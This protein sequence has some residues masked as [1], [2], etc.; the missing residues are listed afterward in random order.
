MRPNLFANTPD[1][2]H[3][4]LQHGGRPAFQ[5]RL[6]P[7]RDARRHLRDLQ[8]LRA[9]ARTSRSSRAARSISTPRSTRSGCATTS[10]RTAWRRLIARI[11]AIRRDHPALQRDRGLRFHD[12]DNPRTSL[13][14]QALARRRRPDPGRRQPRSAPHAA[15]LRPA[16]ARRLGPR[17]RRDGRSRAICSRANATSGAASGTTSG[18]IRRIAVATS[19]TCSCLIRC[20]RSRWRPSRMADTPDPLWYKDAVIYQAHVRAFFDSNDDG[21]GDFR[22]LTQKLDYLQSLGINCALAAAV[23]SVAAARRRL[24]HRRLREHPSELRHAGRLR[25]LHRRGAP[26]RIRVITELVINHT[27]DQH[28]WFQAAR[29]APAG[30]ARARLLRLERHQPEVPG[31]P[32]HLH[33]HRDVELDAGTTP[34]RPTTGIAS[35]TTSP[36]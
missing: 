18:S 21:V 25:A 35:S 3:E 10:S 30:L 15:R 22:G 16:A 26:P 8:R 19:C 32:D 29:H 12:T 36:T 23:L 13:L 33:R 34:P 7:R 24:R 6:R 27:S 17:R 5:I 31:R 28:P 1:I 11:N 4:Y 2:L 9:V 14:Q 20:R